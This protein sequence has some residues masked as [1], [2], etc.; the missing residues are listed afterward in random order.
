MATNPDIATLLRQQQIMQQLSNITNQGVTMP[1]AT[2][3]FDDTGGGSQTTSTGV[4]PLN[5]PS[6]LRQA[7]LSGAGS[8][9][10][11]GPMAALEK[12]AANLPGI[13]QINQG[14]SALENKINNIGKP[15]QN[16]TIAPPQTQIPPAGQQAPL[17]ASTI[18]A[19]G[20]PTLIRRNYDPNNLVQQ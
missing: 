19:G 4:N 10:A 2:K 1:N 14:V 15:P 6:G 9:G 13:K 8:A 17:P 3:Q 5:P 7:L 18:P 20:Q 12:G 16:P 11:S